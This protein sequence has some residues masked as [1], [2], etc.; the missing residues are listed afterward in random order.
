MSRRRHLVAGANGA[1]DRLK[2]EVAH[3]VGVEL[4]DYNPDITA[5]EAGSIGGNM[6][7]KMIETYEEEHCGK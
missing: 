2:N 6:V 4:K 3:E 7:K 1:M 5:R